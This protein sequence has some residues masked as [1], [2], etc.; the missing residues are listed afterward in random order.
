MGRMIKALAM[1]AGGLALAGSALSGSAFA[2]PRPDAPRPA[3]MRA[4][5]QVNDGRLVLAA[6]PG[7]P[8]AAYFTAVNMGPR[9][10][11]I[12]GLDLGRGVRAQF[13]ETRGNAM[14]PLRDIMLMPRQKAELRPGGMHVMVFG[15]RAAPRPGASI[16]A[17]IVLEGGVRLPLTL[18]VTPPGGAMMDHSGMDHSG[19]DHG[20]MGGMDHHHGM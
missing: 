8:M 15:L 12:V 10:V 17:S 4:T 6:V 13:H 11:R 1:M 19:M 5:V 3:P 9:P 18:R 14:L 20:D 16:P 2:Q 7:R